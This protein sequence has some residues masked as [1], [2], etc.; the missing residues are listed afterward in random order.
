MKNLTFDDVLLAHNRIKKHISKTPI[1]SN[2]VL[3][4]ELDAEIFFK[5]E[6]QQ[7]TNAFKA[8]GAFNAVLSYQEKH[9]KLPERIVAHSSGNHAQAV[10][11]VCKNLKIPATIYMAKNASEFKIAATKALGAKV[12]VCE[13]RSEANRLAHE[14]ENEGYFLIH[15]F[16][17]DDVIAGQGTSAFEALTEIGEVDG[18]FV[19]CGGGGFVSG[20]YLAASKLSPSAKVFGSEPKNA[21][22]IAISIRRGEIFS[23]EES[24]N[25]I[26]DGARTLATTPRCFE[27]LKKLSGVFEIEEEK[28]EFWQKKLSKILDQKIEP[29]SA[30]TIASLE[31]YLENNTEAKGGKFLVIISGGNIT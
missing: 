30:L 26:A 3:N 31:E 29:T 15:P 10:A 24:P 5:M 7:L 22:D 18:I 11:L 8:R 12:I 28:I 9:Q 21:N 19:P 27:Y 1:I 17:N 16:D 25:T 2:K 4:K 14:K 20:S 6:N 13:K 23:F